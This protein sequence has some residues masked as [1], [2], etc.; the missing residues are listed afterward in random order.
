MKEE[1]GDR[2]LQVQIIHPSMRCIGFALEIAVLC[3]YRTLKMPR[4]RQW[5]GSD[6]VTHENLYHLWK[7]SEPTLTQTLLRC[8][9]L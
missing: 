3:G 5:G 4:R 7:N 1:S 9:P 8:E 6:F 2:F